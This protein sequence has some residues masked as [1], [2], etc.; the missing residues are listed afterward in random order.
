MHARNAI[1]VTHMVQRR[2]TMLASYS[3]HDKDVSRR[4]AR[5]HVRARSA[6]P[7]RTAMEQ[8]APGRTTPR[9]TQ[10]TTDSAGAPLDK[11]YPDDVRKDDRH[12]VL[13]ESTDEPPSETSRL[14]PM[15]TSASTAPAATATE[16]VTMIPAI[17]TNADT[18]S[19]MTESA[20]VEASVT[21]DAVLAGDAAPRRDYAS[22]QSVERAMSLLSLCAETAADGAT[23]H[24]SVAALARASGLHKSVVARLMATMAH[25]G[26]VVQ[27]PITRAYCIGP[28]AFAVGCTYD[29]QRV[30][31]AAAHQEMQ[32]LTDLC[33][34]S[35]YLAVESGR[36]L[37]FVDDVPSP[38]ALR[39]T[40]GVGSRRPYHALS[41]GKVLLA[42]MPDAQVAAIL[43]SEPLPALTSDTLTD[44]AAVW[45][46]VRAARRDGYALNNGESVVGAGSVA[47]PIHDRHGAVIAGLGIVYP[48]HI[49]SDSEQQQ[50]IHLLLD[51]ASRISAHLG[52]ATASEDVERR[53]SPAS[54]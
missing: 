19:T 45:E 38:R 13:Q 2:C 50:Y 16:P 34:H 1:C 17:T 15:L 28:Q 9:R 53:V 21:V 18:D 4:G 33:G 26:F 51:T 12:T 49:V 29:R 7:T 25:S 44:P 24:R 31:H 6:A 42:G 23:T 30:L 41:I 22:I 11:P 5:W 14:T 10:R 47:V 20:P 37:L 3:G 54:P 43:G 46:H 27:D 40:V 8:Y 32:R 52:H 36:D 39:V 35:S 48:T